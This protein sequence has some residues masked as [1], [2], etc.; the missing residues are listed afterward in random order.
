MPPGYNPFTFESDPYPPLF[1]N[2]NN[3]G[4]FGP[5][6]PQ[7]FGALAPLTKPEKIKHIPNFESWELQDLETSIVKAYERYVMAH[8]RFSTP[9]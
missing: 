7:L 4:D 3:V 1:G 2:M 9:D 5:G 6:A 8:L